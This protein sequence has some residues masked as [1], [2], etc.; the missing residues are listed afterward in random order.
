M[1][2]LWLLPSIAAGVLTAVCLAVGIREYVC[3]KSIEAAS[4][5]MAAGSLGLIVFT[6]LQLHREAQREENR[7]SADADRE[8]ERLAGARAKLKPVAWLARR[9][10][11]QAVIESD[12]ESLNRWLARW[13]ISRKVRMM[14]D[15]P[16]TSAI[17]LLQ[18]Y[19]RE[20]VTLAAEAGA[21]D[22]RV[23]DAA[24]GAFI[25]AANILNDMQARGLTGA[26][27][28][29]TLQADIPNARRAVN[30]L[31]AA[32]R[33]LEAL[34]PRGSEEPRLPGAPRFEGE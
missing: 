23:A 3:H 34:A 24:F 22:V 4:W 9:M 17:D 18:E 5:L 32:A 29:T 1:R 27:D 26:V 8:V 15:A 25:S 16:G 33:A 14:E 12:R 13:Y 10:C 20:A 19:L 6:S 21:D 11:E 2:R 30:Y 7:R 28:T 31:A